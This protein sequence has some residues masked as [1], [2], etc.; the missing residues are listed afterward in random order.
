[1]G[2]VRTDRDDAL[3]DA[4]TQ[5]ISNVSRLSRVWA[6]IPSCILSPEIV[7]ACNQVR[8]AGSAA[9]WALVGAS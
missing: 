9:S 7:C 5:V 1:M 3:K 6:G 8:L 4:D 2:S